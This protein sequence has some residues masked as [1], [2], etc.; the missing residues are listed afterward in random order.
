MSKRTLDPLTA[1]EWKVMRAVW[2]QGDCA[3]RAVYEVC[4]TRHGMAVST[5]KT[6]LNHVFPKL[7]VNTRAELAAAYVRESGAETPRR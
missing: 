5:V 1:A 7:G 2:E 6:H 4:G 3:A